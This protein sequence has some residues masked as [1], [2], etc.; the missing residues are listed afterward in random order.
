MS[1]KLEK[2]AAE[3][4][5]DVYKRQYY[6]C[7]GTVSFLTAVY[8]SVPDGEAVRRVDVYKRQATTSFRSGRTLPRCC[9]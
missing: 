1:L 9:A 7:I 2:I 3:R 8:A 4:E 6:N 5:K